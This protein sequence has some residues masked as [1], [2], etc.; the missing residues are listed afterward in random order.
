MGPVFS[1]GPDLFFEN[2]VLEYNPMTL[3]YPVIDIFTGE[4]SCKYKSLRGYRL[5]C[6]CADCK[7]EGAKNILKCRTQVR[8]I[9]DHIRNCQCCAD[10]GRTDIS[11]ILHFHHLTNN[12]NDRKPRDCNG[13]ISM[14]RELRKGIFLCPTCHTLR[15]FDPVTGLVKT[16]L[17]ELR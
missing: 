12:E 2:P 4:I 11:H 14:I 13:L 1:L 10:C 9:Y 16:S 15:H 8:Q 17:S 7:G 6:K 3:P 5:G